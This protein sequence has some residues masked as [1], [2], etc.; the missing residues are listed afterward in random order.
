MQPEIKRAVALGSFDGIHK[1]HQAVLSGA[2]DLKEK[3]LCPTILLFDVHPVQVLTGC[4]PLCLFQSDSRDNLIKG[5]GLESESISFSEIMNMS[6]AEFFRRVLVEKLNAGAVC[7]GENYRFGKGG[8]GSTEDLERLCRENGIIL[9]VSPSVYYEGEIISSTRIRNAILSGCTGDANA[10]LGRAFSYHL[11]VD[12]GDE[13]GRLLGFPTINQ[14]FPEGFIIPKP[15]VYA[16]S[17]NI[18]G[19]E[20]AGVTNIGRR[21]SFDDDERRSE[22]HI[23]GVSEDLYGRDIEVR[24][25]SFI[26]ESARFTSLDELSRHINEDCKKAKEIFSEVMQN[27]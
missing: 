13:R 24:L 12:H 7:C 2:V 9:S 19:K 27:V 4:A 8:A 26:R 16:S 17:V 20:Y 23:I 15:G 6:P 10:M 11:I 21:P 22:T 25:H 14:H 18:N 5:M 3:G 1:G